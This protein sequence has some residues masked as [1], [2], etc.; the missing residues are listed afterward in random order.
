MVLLDGIIVI[1]VAGLS[2]CDAFASY[3]KERRKEKNEKKKTKF[4][5][6]IEVF[7]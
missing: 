4:N 5:G 3:Q 7:G 6:L 1:G 2:S